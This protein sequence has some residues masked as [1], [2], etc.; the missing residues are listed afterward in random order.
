MASPSPDQGGAQ[1]REQL[2]ALRSLLVLFMLLTQ[3]DSETSILHF[4]ANAVGPLCHCTT[5]GILLDGQW[6]D[7]W[8]AGQGDRPAGTPVIIYADFSADSSESMPVEMAGVP[9][10]Y[11]YSLGSVH[12]PSG[13]LVDFCFGCSLSRRGWRCPTCGCSAGRGSAPPNCG[14]PTWPWPAAWRCIRR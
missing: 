2:S 10:S 4:V 8:P 14:P 5:H 13:Y 12:G 1:A 3:Q 7:I 11:A 9:W 6:R